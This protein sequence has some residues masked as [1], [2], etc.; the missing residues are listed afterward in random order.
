MSDGSEPEFEKPMGRSQWPLRLCWRTFKK[1]LIL[2]K[3]AYSCRN[4][5]QHLRKE[6]PR[7]MH[8]RDQRH[9]EY[10]Y[11]LFPLYRSTIPTVPVHLLPRYSSFLEAITQPPTSHPISLPRKFNTRFLNTYLQEN[12][13]PDNVYSCTN[14]SKPQSSQL[15]NGPK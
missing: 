5:C 11:Y 14:P 6:A 1:R 4:T 7:R 10:F 15:Y 2:D 13:L 12:D 8:L 9:A 3:T